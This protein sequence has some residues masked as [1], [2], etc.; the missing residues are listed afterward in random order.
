M[1]TKDISKYFGD[2]IVR[3]IEK[4][5]ASD[6]FRLVKSNAGRLAEFFPNT[7]PAN[8]DPGASKAFIS[9]CIKSRKK[10]E[11]DCFITRS[12]REGEIVGVVFLKNFDWKAR[13]CELSYFVDGE[14]EKMGIASGSVMVILKY[15]FDELELTR[16]I[17]R[18]AVYNLASRRVLEKNG[19]VLEGTLRQD[20]KTFAGKWIDLA[21]YGLLKKDFCLESESR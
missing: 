14:H 16:I 17:A 12:S 8:R 3:Q 2:Y 15:C 1:T 13:K 18:A 7:V 9:N 6:Y 20:Y 5:D 4:D 11:F 10:K 21:Y 19:F